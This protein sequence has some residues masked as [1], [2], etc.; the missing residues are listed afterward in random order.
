MV[1]QLNKTMYH[2]IATLL[3]G[4]KAQ[5]DKVVEELRELNTALS[6]NDRENIIEELADVELVL[7]YLK[8]II[9]CPSK[10]EVKHSGKRDYGFGAV[11][12]MLSIDAYNSENLPSIHLNRV[13]DSIAVYV[14][15]SLACIYSDYGINTRDV[16]EI[17]AQKMKRTLKRGIGRS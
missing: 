16:D 11:V 4:R 1:K 9:G 7:P 14:C 17:K 3:Y 10:F 15:Q 13:I 5:L 12:L 8:Q 6:L 2:T